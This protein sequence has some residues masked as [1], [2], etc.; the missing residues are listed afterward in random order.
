MSRV[1]YLKTEN[2]DLSDTEGLYACMNC[3]YV[4]YDSEE[5]LEDEKIELCPDCGSSSDCEFG[6]YDNL[7]DEGDDE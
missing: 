4:G 1:V 2:I 3:G 5:S 6:F 7:P